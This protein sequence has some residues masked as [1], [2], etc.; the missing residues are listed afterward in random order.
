MSA[1]P[2]GVAEAIRNGLIGDRVWFYS[3]YH[4]NLACTY[5]LTGSGPEAAP[6]ILGPARMRSMASEAAALGFGSVGVTGGE[7]FLLTGMPE[8]LADLS[9]VLPVVV[10]S[11]GTL[12]HGARLRSLEAL[13]S[14]PVTIQI[15]LDH[16]D[17]GPNDAMR[18]PGNFARVVEA[19]PRLV[20]LGLR[21]RIATTGTDLGEEEMGRLCRLHRELGVADEDH[22]VRPIARRGRAATRGMGIDA[23][24]EQFEPEL[25]ITADGSFWSPFAPTVTAGRLD[26]DMLL[27]RMT[28]PLAI[29]AAA[30]LRVL[31]ARP[32]ADPA[33]E[34]FT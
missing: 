16:P 2:G 25:T 4:C 1:V 27:T 22:V 29:A 17:P 21:V 8:L 18:G 30:M 9:D 13:A 15:S 19:V 32:P 6:R 31:E 34:R 12:F 20:E 33:A 10:L 23:P 28:S 7:P 14:Q 3:N 24:W 26:T 5:C 11:N